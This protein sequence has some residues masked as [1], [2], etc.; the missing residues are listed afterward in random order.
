MVRLQQKHQNKL[1]PID[2]K[3]IKNEIELLKASNGSIVKEQT[4]EVKRFR[5]DAED[6]RRQLK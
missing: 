3:S 5:K 2:L 6:V 4:T 1:E